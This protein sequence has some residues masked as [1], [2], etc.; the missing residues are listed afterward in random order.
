MARTK[1]RCSDAGSPGQLIRG[2]RSDVDHMAARVD[3]HVEPV[4]RQ[5]VIF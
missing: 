4:I 5:V 1:A 2:L 3:E